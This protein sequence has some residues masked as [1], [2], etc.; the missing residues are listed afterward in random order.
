MIFKGIR[1]SIAKKPY[2]FLFFQGGPDPLSLLWI[3]ACTVTLSSLLAL[4][5]TDSGQCTNE[6]LIYS[7]LQ[8]VDWCLLHNLK[9]KTELSAW[10]AKSVHD[11]IKNLSGVVIRE[12]GTVCYTLLK[13][14]KRIQYILPFITM[15]MN[16]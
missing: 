14:F 1:T 5:F 3:R 10:F 2:I 8:T 16:S 6:K 7:W 12:P 9:C 13:I 11:I 15:L 4:K